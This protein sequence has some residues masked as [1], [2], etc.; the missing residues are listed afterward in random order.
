[1]TDNRAPPYT[2]KKNMTP[3]QLEAHKAATRKYNR[4][5]MRAHYEDRYARMKERM[6]TD[7]E[8]AAKM[9]DMSARANKKRRGQGI[10]ETP[11]QRERRLQ[12]DREYAAKRAREKKLMAELIPAKAKAPAPKAPKPPAAPKTPPFTLRKVGR[13]L[14]LS[15]WHGF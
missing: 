1:M 4:E 7:P 11:E 15:R 10:A 13:I 6:A 9:K 2:R 12:R 14:A 8:Y 5:W 3:E